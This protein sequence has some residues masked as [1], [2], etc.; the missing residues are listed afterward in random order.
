[1]AGHHVDGRHEDGLHEDQQERVLRYVER[2]AVVLEDS[3][4]PRMAARVFAFALADDADRYTAAELARGLRVSPAAVSG[5]VRHL[6]RAGL[7]GKE[8]APGS[9]VEQYRIYDDDVWYRIYRQQTQVLERYQEAAA[10]GVL[11]LG[12]DS[13]GGRRMRETEEFF[14]F[15]R[16]EVPDLLER[17]RARRAALLGAGA[18]P[19]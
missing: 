19:P 9:R 13:P 8:R 1:M 4:L 17:W 5:A 3:G 11:A 2:F 10:D 7:L 18:P 14:A 12:L 6:V 15:L 16:E